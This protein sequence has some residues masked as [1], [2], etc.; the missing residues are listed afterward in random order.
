MLP[1]EILNKE[2][3]VLTAK[4]VEFC[5]LDIR[6]FEIIKG[7]GFINLAQH[8]ISVGAEHGV[9][10]VSNV[11]PHPTTIS[12]NVS[13]VKLKKHTE[14][15]PIVEKALKNGECAATSDGW[16]D[17]HKKNN[18]LT[19]TIHFF[20]EDFVLQS[21]VL[22]TSLFNVKSKTGVAIRNE[23]LAKFKELGFNE[24]YF[25]AMP[26]VTDKGGNMVCAF[27]GRKFN[28]KN[29]AAHVLNRIL[30]N[31]FEK[32]APVEVEI[33]IDNCK[34][35]VRHFKQSSKLNELP[36]TV[37]Q[38]TESRWNSKLTLISSITKQYD[39]IMSLLTETQRNNWSFRVD[40]ANEIIRFLE[41]FKE[42]S[43]HLEGENYPTFNLILLWRIEI[44]K[45]LTDGQF[46]GPV[47][48]LAK[49]ALKYLEEKLPVLMEYKIATFLDPRYRHMEML[50]D[51]ERN[52][53]FIEVLSLM[54]DIRPP[55]IETASQSKKARYSIYEGIIE[56]R[57]EHELK[58]YI[59]TA[60][61]SKQTESKLVVQNF[62][63]ENKKN[64]PK[65]YILAKRKLCVPATSGPSERTFSGSGRTIDPRRTNI[66]PKI[67]DDLLY[68]RD[69]YLKTN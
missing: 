28:R 15:L 61:Y 47:K 19:M 34:A 31:T 9:I 33:L 30:A 59:E 53:V 69:S 64:F 35:I 26:M 23:I 42:A 50:T 63:K 22:F 46:I 43:D 3:K 55:E 13:D 14:L 39:H 58:S 29:C 8:F 6:P 57:D 11:L 56:N 44:L 16:C 7:K 32:H 62:W 41:P 25:F 17:D 45:H 21:K 66:K 18:Y 65:L 5:A 1:K 37:K 54:K 2:K 20:D 60:M 4:I 48:T 52:D 27:K 49:Y 12:R 24:K 40:L 10:D 67:L 36:F 68:I 51:A 38:E